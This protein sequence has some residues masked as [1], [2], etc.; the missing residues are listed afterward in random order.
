MNNIHKTAIIGT[1]YWGSIIANTLIK[2]T[3]KKIIFNNLSIYVD[4]FDKRLFYIHP[5]KVLNFVKSEL[6]KNC[7]LDHSYILKKNVLPYEFTT[8]IL[9]DE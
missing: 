7:I 3:K 8:V 5:S 2:I 6:N 1:G 9:K 4:Y